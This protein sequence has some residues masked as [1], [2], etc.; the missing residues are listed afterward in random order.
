MTACEHEAQ[1]SV[2]RI[3]LDRGGPWGIENGWKL[4]DSG[5]NECL[6]Y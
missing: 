6:E 5:G 3:V 4:V 2:L 1:A